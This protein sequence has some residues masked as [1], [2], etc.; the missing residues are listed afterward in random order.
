MKWKQFANTVF[1]VIVIVFFAWV[2]FEVL[3]DARPFNWFG[4]FI[5]FLIGCVLIVIIG[6]ILWCVGFS[7]V[8]LFRNVWD[9]LT[10]TQKQREQI[11]EQ[12]Q[13]EKEEEKARQSFIDDLRRR[14][15]LK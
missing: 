1:V 6:I 12:R 9:L 2:F 11:K 14:G 4:E 5:W 8:E 7:L 10:K 3:E 13:Q 15:L